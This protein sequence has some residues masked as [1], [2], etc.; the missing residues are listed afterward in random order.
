M[1]QGSFKESQQNSITFPEISTPIL[2]K[3]IQ[4]CCYKVRYNN[5]TT[6]VPEF[7]IEPEIALELLI[8]SNYLDL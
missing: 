6:R 7:V 2:E 4:Y 8:S 3:T 5:S 1:L